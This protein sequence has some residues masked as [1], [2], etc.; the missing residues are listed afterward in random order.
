MAIIL[1]IDPAHDIS[2]I[3]LRLSHANLEVTS[4]MPMLNIITVAATPSDM[5]DIGII[6]GVIAVE[7]DREASISHDGLREGA[8]M[9]RLS[10]PKTLDSELDAGFTSATIN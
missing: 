3:I 9:I 5:T 8:T 2:Q 6:P 7:S 4:V 10:H 1:T